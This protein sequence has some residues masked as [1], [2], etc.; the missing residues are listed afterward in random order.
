MSFQKTREKT[1][2]MRNGKILMKN[3]GDYWTEDQRNCVRTMF[4]E[5][6]PVNEIAIK[7]E[8][9]EN[10]VYQ[11]ILQMD[12]YTRAPEKTRKRRSGPKEPVCL[13]SVC[14][15]DRLLCPLC[16]VYQAVQEDE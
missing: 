15:C 3:D 16:E 2:A 8:R 12:L 14:S 10:A 5:G 7:L 13:C 6:V 9:S 11:Q 4:A 1:I